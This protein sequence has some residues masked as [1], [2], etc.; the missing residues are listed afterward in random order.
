LDLDRA[1]LVAL[2]A[3]DEKQQQAIPVLGLDAIRID[4]HGNGESSIE[5]PSEPFPAVR[6]RL[7]GIREGLLARDPD[8]VLFCLDVELAAVDPWQFNNRY[9][10]L[11]LLKD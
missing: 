8:R 3:P 2:G 7:F 10:V 9:Q 4:L 5:H 6:A 1:R 11:A